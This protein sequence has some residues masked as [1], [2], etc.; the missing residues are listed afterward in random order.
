MPQAR[1]EWQKIRCR[2]SQLGPAV[3]VVSEEWGATCRRSLSPPVVFIPPLDLGEK[4]IFAFVPLLR[5]RRLVPLP[6]D[7]GRGQLFGGSR[8]VKLQAGP[9]QLPARHR[10]ELC[11]PAPGK[12]HRQLREDRSTHTRKNHSR[13]SA[14]L[15]PVNIA[16]D[17]GRGVRD[18]QAAA[19]LVEAHI[20][21]ERRDRQQ[22]S[23]W[24]I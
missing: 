4:R 14:G 23:G 5:P 13:R 1:Q 22:R 16:R 15:S 20:P 18:N 7:S 10:S 17:V 6:R 9:I 19:S 8:F 2:G 21:A 3:P 24:V 11:P 12:C